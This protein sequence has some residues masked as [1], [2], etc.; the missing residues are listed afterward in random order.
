M[1][2]VTTGITRDQMMP[3]T[4]RTTSG[5]LRAHARAL[6]LPLAAK[7]AAFQNMGLDVY[8][9]GVSNDH[10]RNCGGIRFQL[11]LTK[12][13][14]KSR[15]CHHLLKFSHAQPIVIASSK[16]AGTR[17]PRPP[18]IVSLYVNQVGDTT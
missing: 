1:H 2:A 11:S 13:G 12:S 5:C 4:C 10:K 8:I 9:C 16:V 7:A 3:G 15:S 14:P 6:S 18:W 17:A